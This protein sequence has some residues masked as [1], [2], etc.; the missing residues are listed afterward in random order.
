MTDLLLSPLNDWHLGQNARMVPFAGMS[1]PVQYAGGIK[2]EHLAVRDGCGLFDISHMVQIRVKAAEGVAPVLTA[3]ETVFPIDFSRFCPGLT[4]YSFLLSADGGI[5]DDVMVSHAGDHV[6]IVANGARR[7]HDPA[8]LRS[9]L[10]AHIAI[11]ILDEQAFLAIQGPDAASIM[12]DVLPEALS[13]D[14]MCTAELTWRNHRLRVFRQGYAGE[15]GFEISL[16]A[17]IAAD[18]AGAL[19]AN[20]V[21]TPAGL[22]ARDSLRLE[23]GLPLWGQD[24]DANTTPL[25]ANLD[26]AIAKVRRISGGFVGAGVIIPQCAVAPHKSLVG[27]VF[28][29]KQPARA[30]ANV[31]HDDNP[32]SP[33]IG[34]ITSGGISPSRNQPIALAR[35]E[36]Q[37]CA[38]GAKVF[39][40]V[41]GKM[42]A[43]TITALP[44]VPHRY[45]RTPSS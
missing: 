18:F 7:D 35:L 20:P 40:K 5:L 15:D 14:F 34:V 39:A 38:A 23:A 1:L 2:T 12:A 13:L 36:R 41:R 26:F 10:P 16:S 43:A 25:T 32:Q 9:L 37:H 30:G 17:N 31:H 8:Y 4:K 22:G 11:N 27:M 33:P 29:S 42:L 21:V 6:M 3:L 44:F 45:Y 28:A 24:I 19:C